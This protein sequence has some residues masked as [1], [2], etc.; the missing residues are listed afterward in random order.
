MAVHY[1]AGRFP[2]NERLDWSALV[3]YIGPAAA[4]LARY[5]GMLAAV[6]NPDILIAPLTT[7]EAILS[8][9]IEGTVA[10]MGDVLGFEAGQ[11][12][13]SPARRDDFQEVLNYR[14]ALRRAEELLAELP[15]SLRVVREAHAVLMRGV[16]GK[17]KAPGE[18]RRLSNWIGPPGCT[19][20]EATFVPVGAEAL[21]AAM[22]AWERYIHADAPDRLVQ[23]AVLHAE[24]EA[25]HPFLDGNGRLGRMLVPLFLWQFGLI[26]V[27]R[28]YISAF[29][30]A[31]RDA[32]YGGLLSVSR[33]DDWT[34]WCRFFLEAVRAQAEAD[35]KKADGIIR[36]YDETVKQVADLTRSHQAIR[37]MGW[38]FAHPIFL[39][40]RFV[41]S[42]G[43]PEPTARR[44][45]RVLVR[46][47]ILR[48]L[49]AGR[50]RRTGILAFPELLNAAEGRSP[51]DGQT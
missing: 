16:R 6:P 11:T 48:V 12:P 24:F 4:A 5:D 47:G 30:E 26:G 3:P 39:T 27:P 36:L 44:F 29:F 14:S 17:G 38:I 22:S 49:R 43:I 2:P 42:A 13:D 8:S 19:I 1:H 31:R 20:D 9:R 37:A 45:L 23:L 21:P 25:L 50:G 34:G 18:F 35:L 51:V 33:D 40:T 7:N 32:Y 15:L 46:D 10:T 28:F 41:T